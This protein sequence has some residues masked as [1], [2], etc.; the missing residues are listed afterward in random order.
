VTPRPKRT[1]K[2]DNHAEIVQ[3]LRDDGFV[4]VDVADLPGDPTNNP[5]DVFVR[6][7]EDAPVIVALSAEG[8]RR[9]F[10][11]HPGAGW[12][13]VEIK[14]SVDAPFTDAEEEYLRRCGWRGEVWA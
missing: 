8:V 6:A 10:E 9:W 12:V 1:R 4:V 11:E 5:L 14:T 3:D 7:A 2:D 13:Q